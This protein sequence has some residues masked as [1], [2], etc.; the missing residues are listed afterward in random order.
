M[1]LPITPET[2]VGA[3]LEAYPG[4]EEILI[5]WVPAF[6][7]LRN[8]ILR[9]TVAKVATLD[10]AARIGGIPA[11][12][13]V[14]KL[15]EATGQDAGEMLP[16]GETKPA[17]VETAGSL[18]GAIIRFEIDADRM[19]ETGE[20]PLG[21]MRRCA[22]QLG[23]NEVVRLTSSFRPVPLIDAFASAGFQVHSTHH[24]PGRYVTDIGPKS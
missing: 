6:A 16:A 22:A 21:K 1:N 19:L 13:L 10:Q 2:K 20:H 17:P 11:R 8:P 7:K 5:G 9:K 14:R 12:E 15:R 24:G 3:L 4:I 23:P 18:D